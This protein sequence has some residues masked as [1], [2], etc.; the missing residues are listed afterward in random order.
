MDSWIIFFLCPNFVCPDL[1][2][3]RR[4][5]RS[6]L[7]FTPGIVGLALVV[8]LAMLRLMASASAESVYV[9]GRELRWG[10]A[11][12]KMF[13]IPC[14]TCGLTRGVLLS[15][16]GQFAEAWVLNPAGPLIVLGV[17]LLG[18]AMFF[19]TFYQA[20]HTPPAAGRIHRHIRVGSSAY[21]GVVVV[22]LA[23][24]WLAE[25]F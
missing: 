14:P 1:E 13:G 20:S 6:K 3:M 11:F 2:R 21:A 7:N 15:L 8:P 17:L 12:Q 24:H 25:V 16:H 4:R 10:C 18:L 22:A 23:V 9:A 19:L 5:L